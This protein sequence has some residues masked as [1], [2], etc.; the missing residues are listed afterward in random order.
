MQK[1]CANL[2]AQAHPELREQATLQT[3]FEEKYAVLIKWLV[4]V[5]DAFLMA[6][7]DMGDE[8]NTTLDFV[9][10]HDKLLTEIKVGGTT[11]I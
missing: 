6:N 1:H 8:M 2:Q 9:E 4:N 11:G 5:G 7:N 10:G 3:T